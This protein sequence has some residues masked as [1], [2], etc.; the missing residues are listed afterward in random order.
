MFLRHWSAPLLIALL[1]VPSIVAAPRKAKKPAT[2]SKSSGKSAEATAQLLEAAAAGDEDRILSA[3]AAGADVN[4]RDDG[5]ATPLIL[6]APNSLF[7]KERKVVEA[8][9]KAGAKVDAADKDG[10]T[11]LMAAASTGR[12]GMV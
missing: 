12:D 10:M 7:M 5:Q 9:V 3:I 8:F 11:P 2:S 6:T 1:V 4:A